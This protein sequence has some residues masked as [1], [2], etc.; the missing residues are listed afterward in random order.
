MCSEDAAERLAAGLYYRALRLHRAEHQ[1]LAARERA[2]LQF[3]EKVAEL[4]QRVARAH[5]AS[6][7]SY[8]LSLAARTA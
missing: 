2:W 8:M 4:K 3:G 6:G 5:T 1:R 7:H